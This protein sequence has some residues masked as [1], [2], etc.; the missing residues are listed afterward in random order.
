MRTYDIHEESLIRMLINELQLPENMASWLL[1]KG[2]VPVPDDVVFNKASG[3]RMKKRPFLPVFDAGD[4]FYPM[5]RMADGRQ[6]VASIDVRI[7]VC[8]VELWQTIHFFRFQDL[9]KRCS[10]TVGNHTF[11]KDDYARWKVSIAY[12]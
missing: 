10:F 11:S 4:H 3:A 5:P 8:D 9:P 2:V 6:L 12:S 1:S 7:E